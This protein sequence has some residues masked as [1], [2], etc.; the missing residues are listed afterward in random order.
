MMMPT[1]P[2]SGVEHPDGEACPVREVEADHQPLGHGRDNNRTHVLSRR[3]L[4]EQLDVWPP[5]V[6]D[7]EHGRVCLN[8]GRERDAKKRR[9]HLGDFSEHLTD[10]VRA[11]H[12]LN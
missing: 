11:G 1:V 9:L 3:R 10:R 12:D 2:F 6:G 8:P 5:V 4:D 7:G